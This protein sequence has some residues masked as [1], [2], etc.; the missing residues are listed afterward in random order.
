[1]QNHN[2]I[3][4]PNPYCRQAASL[5]PEEI[6]KTDDSTPAEQAIENEIRQQLQIEAAAVK[7][8]V[9]QANSETAH[10]GGHK[11]AAQRKHSPIHRRSSGTKYPLRA[12]VECANDVKLR[13]SFDKEAIKLAVASD[14]LGFAQWLFPQGRK[15][16]RHW[17]IGNVDGEPGESLVVSISGQY[18]GHFHDWAT[19][20]RGDCIQLVMNV[21]D[22]DFGG[23][24]NLLAVRYSSAQ[25]AIVSENPSLRRDRRQKKR[26][27]S[28]GTLRL[29]N[30]RP[31]SDTDLT[32]L[33]K[34]RN[35]A[36]EALKIATNRGLLWFYDSR[37]GRAFAVTDRA[38]K[39]IQAR[40]LDGQPW[41]WNKKKA[42]TLKGSA[43]PWPIGLQESA[44]F[45][46]I[47]ICEGG[48]DFLAAFHH[49]LIAGVE[50]E[51][52]PICM[53]GAS[54]TIPDECIAGFAE[55]HI[56]IFVHDDEEGRSAS[57]RW[58]RQLRTADSRIDGFTFDGLVRTDGNPVKDLCDLASIHVDSWELN[59]STVESCM[60]FYREGG[61]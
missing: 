9:V 5:R 45:P 53:T 21:R 38:R 30:L 47:A 40:R 56:R 3:L 31:G 27:A 34:L 20:L 6:V 36:I 58:A 54:L 39:N 28:Q 23:A 33:S 2:Q 42:W 22:V 29:P 61:E 1:M 41:R 12:P 10:G 25:P 17:R 13:R 19:G 48:P 43:A 4:Q 50:T 59:H 18:P 46:N 60:A 37:E 35:I 15:F 14:A 11:P 26:E 57:N 44:E 52:A 7:E 8:G 24:L 51:V 32:H 16:G 49:A 55:K